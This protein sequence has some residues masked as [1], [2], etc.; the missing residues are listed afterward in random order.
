MRKKKNKKQ[1]LLYL[2][3]ERTLQCLDAVGQWQ[4]GRPACRKKNPVLL[5]GT[6]LNCRKN[7]PGNAYDK[8]Y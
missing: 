1:K 6:P 8:N 7:R 2:L 5:S 3:I 4:E